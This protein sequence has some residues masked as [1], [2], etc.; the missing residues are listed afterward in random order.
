MIPFR[1][2]YLEPSNVI[3]IAD[4][5]I[6]VDFLDSLPYEDPMESLLIELNK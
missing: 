5:E 3:S 6:E 4:V 2:E 1:V